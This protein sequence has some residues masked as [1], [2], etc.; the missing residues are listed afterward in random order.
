MNVANDLNV[1]GLV[2]F[3]MASGEATESGA[4][5]G[6]GPYALTGAGTFHLTGDNSGL[7]GTVVLDNTTADLAFSF[8]PSAMMRTTST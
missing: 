7:T 5:S 6:D 4:L 1:S 3:N 8:A 2:N